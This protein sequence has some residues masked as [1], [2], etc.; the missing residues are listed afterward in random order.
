[1]ED[2]LRCV[3][4]ELGELVYGLLVAV[5]WS[6]RSSSGGRGGMEVTL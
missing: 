4:T 2:G 6:T 5:Q 1:M 3:E